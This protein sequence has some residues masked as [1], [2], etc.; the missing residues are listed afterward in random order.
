MDESCLWQSNGGNTA[1][2]SHLSGSVRIRHNGVTGATFANNGDLTVVGTVRGGNDILGNT[3]FGLEASFWHSSIT[4]ASNTV[5]LSQSS[6]GET[7]LQ[8]TTGNPVRIAVQGATIVQIDTSATAVTGHLTVSGNSTTAGTK[9][10]TIDGP[11]VGLPEGSKLMHCTVESPFPDN[12]Y[13]LLCECDEGWNTFELPSWFDALNAAD[14][15]VW[16]TGAGHWKN[17]YGVVSGNTVSLNCQ[18]SGAWNVLV[19]ARR[20]AGVIDYPGPVVS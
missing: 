10:F 7:R 12:Q 8:S 14:G 16:C 18:A 4:P 17:A 6:S 11:L 1:I 5:A 2:S 20:V 13:R 15:Q 3:S 9:S 19:I